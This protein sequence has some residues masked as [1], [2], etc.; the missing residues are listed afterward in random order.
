[1][2]NIFTNLS[3]IWPK[4]EDG[5]F[6]YQLGNS[7]DPFKSIEILRDYLEVPELSAVIN[8]K[9][10]AFR[11][12]KINLVNDKGDIIKENVDLFNYPNFFQG[13]GE[14][15]RQ[16][17]LFHEIYGNEF[18]YLLKG[19][20][21]D[22]F[23]NVKAMFTLP[24]SFVKIKTSQNSQFWLE[25]TLPDDV[26]YF[27]LH[28]N[29]E[30]E[31]D[32][33]DVI[34]LNDNKIDPV[35]T[36]DTTGSYLTGTSKIELLKP[37]LNNIRAAYA[38]RGTNLTESGPRG[39][40][41]NASADGAG[42]TI[43]LNPVEVEKIHKEMK[44]Y[45][46]QKNQRR[47]II[48]NL[49]LSWQ[50]MGFNTNQL[51]A[52]EEVNDDNLR[53]CDE[54]GIPIDIFSR[55]KGSTFENKRQAKKDAY[56][57]TIIPESIEWIDGLNNKLEFKQGLKLAVSFAHLPIFAEDRKQSAEALK[58]LIEGLDKAFLSGAITIEEYKEQIKK[59][60]S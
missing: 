25:T 11:N 17:K 36:N 12:A 8:W 19:L 10:S 46:S 30:I 26:Q 43:P 15:L 52:F 32:T 48:T 56:Q 31:I 21:S 4:K 13:K 5:T 58:T 34:H 59:Y 50:S 35:M 7:Y 45:G 57:D 24:P 53:I 41:T 14:F 44:K 51:K 6:F 55:E 16:T 23:E 3:R 20:K 18:I 47:N 40:L 33:E 39:I 29:K 42:G 49:A 2:G 54:F 1:M 38:A 28:N 60:M 27:I 37:V 22:Y 9:A